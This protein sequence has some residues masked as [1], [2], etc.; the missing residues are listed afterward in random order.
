MSAGSEKS[1]SHE[2]SSDDEYGDN[3][4]GVLSGCRALAMPQ[5]GPVDLTPPS[6]TNSASNPK[7]Q[8]DAI[9]PSTGNL[10]PSSKSKSPDSSH[11]TSTSQQPAGTGV[12]INKQESGIGISI[13][14]EQNWFV[15][16]T[17]ADNDGPDEFLEKMD[18]LQAKLNYLMERVQEEHESC[19]KALGFRHDP[20]KDE[21][22]GK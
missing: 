1:A 2:G 16:E 13:K 20:S 4:R 17:E 12:T 18:R 22:S 19:A 21:S 11:G 9:L 10:K 3:D 15:T 6:A 7:A 5:G 8:N 14:Q